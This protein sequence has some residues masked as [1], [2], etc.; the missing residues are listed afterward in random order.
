MKK[1]FGISKARKFQEKF[2]RKF[3][4]KKFRFRIK[5]K[6]TPKNRA[7]SH[8]VWTHMISDDW[9]S[10]EIKREMFRLGKTQIQN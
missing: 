7:K 1:K 8:T 9:S 6:P 2:P 5:M 10:A 4:E 3:T